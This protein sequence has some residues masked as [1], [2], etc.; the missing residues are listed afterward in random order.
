VGL[1]PHAKFCRP[2]GARRMCGRDG[3]T[4]TATT[5]VV[6]ASRP[7]TIREPVRAAKQRP[8]EGFITV[9]VD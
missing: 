2:F 9:R 7:H 1:T 8:R 5:F 6:R 4:T 3:H